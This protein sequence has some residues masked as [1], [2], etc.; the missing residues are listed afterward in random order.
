MKLNKIFLGLLGV[1]AFTLASCSEEDSYERATVSGP[2]VFF[3]DTT[4]TAFE[5]S[6]DATTFDVPISR[7]DASGALTVNLSSTTQNSMY[8]IP[9]SVSF[10]A[11]EKT[12]NIPVSYDPANIEYGR[13]DTLTVKIADDAQATSWGVQELVFTAGVTDWGPWQKWNSAGT[14][15]YTYVNF[16]S[17]D[18][19]DLPFVYRHNMIKTNLYQFKISNWGYGVDLVFDYDDVTGHVTCATQW[20]GYDHSSYGYVYCSDLSTYAVIR[21]WDIED[22]FYGTFDKEQGIITVPLVYHVDAGYF[23]YDP[24]YL[25]IDG[26]VRADYSSALSYAG[27]FTD[28]AGSVFAVGNLTLGADATDVKAVVI[29]AEADADLVGEAL[30]AGELEGTDVEGGMIYVPIPENKTGKLQIVTAVVVDGEAKSIASAG[31]EYYGGGANPWQSLG[32]GYY[33]DDFVVSLYTEEGMSYTYEVEIQES[34]D[35]PGLYRLVNAYAPVAEGFGVEGGNQNIEINAED[36]EAVYVDDQFTGLDFGQGPISIQSW[37]S[38][39]MQ[40][41]DVATLKDA[42]YLG[43]V[44][45]GVITLPVFEREASDGSTMKYQGLTWI[46]DNGYYGCPNGEFKVVLPSAA[47]EVRAKARSAAKASDFARRLFGASLNAH[48][49]QKHIR[50]LMVSN[51]PIK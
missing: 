24:E 27:T 19:L 48:K 38:Y 30:A 43:E 47:A 50:A 26:Y 4:P 22:D 46:G 31:F 14:A 15:D 35:V 36:P 34:T 12:T 7:A 18:D 33:T 2:Q 21:G 13:Y 9:S 45:D 32:I 5:I 39:Y 40:K 8:S 42:G 20:T 49:V 37:G 17:G 6:P 28:V 51:D 44:V 29:E 23:G 16:W 25:Y 1:A 10:N 41:Y 3:S 11:G